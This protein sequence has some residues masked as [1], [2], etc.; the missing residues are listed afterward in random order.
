MSLIN[1]E[2]VPCDV[3]FKAT[4]IA[5]QSVA[6]ADIQGNHRTSGVLLVFIGVVIIG[7]ALDFADACQGTFDG[8]GMGGVDGQ[9]EAYPGFAIALE[10][11]DIAGTQRGGLGAGV[12]FGRH[13]QVDTCK[14]GV[15][16]QAVHG[17]LGA[18]AK[19]RYA[20][21]AHH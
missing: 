17:L 11:L 15:F 20:Q 3:Q 1:P 8:V 10:A 18:S 4:G 21:Q 13:F 16:I 6:H 12:E 7:A 14:F 5:A 9:V 19:A 2:A